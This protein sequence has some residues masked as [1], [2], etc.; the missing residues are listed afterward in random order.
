MT[1]QSVLYKL[2]QLVSQGLGANE[3]GRTD[4]IK[5]KKKNDSLGVGFSKKDAVGTTVTVFLRF[6]G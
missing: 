2:L 1:N 6:N 4:V 5:V 3:D